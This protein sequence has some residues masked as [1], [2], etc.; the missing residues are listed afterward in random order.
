MIG[1]ILVSHG[2]LAKGL[3]D[4]LQMITGQQKAIA[5]L[6]LNETDAV[7]EL[8]ERI[9]TAVDQ[10]AGKE[11][12]LILVDV[13]GASPFNASARLALSRPTQKIDVITGMNLPML[14]EL[15]TQRENLTLEDAVAAACKSGSQGIVTLSDLMRQADL[16]ATTKP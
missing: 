2:G 4:A 14:I 12:T 11:G 8:V 5:S 6:A 15:V 16:A 3:L 13:L 10:T 1:I 9:G 7:D